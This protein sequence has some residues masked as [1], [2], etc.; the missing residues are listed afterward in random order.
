MDFVN[1]GMVANQASPVARIVEDG[2][3]EFLVNILSHVY[4]PVLAAA[5]FV[6]VIVQ[7][8]AGLHIA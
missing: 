4:S 3:N 5:R 1:D 7:A 6:A 2:V 8:F